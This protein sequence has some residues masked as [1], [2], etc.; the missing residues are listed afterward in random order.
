M[1]YWS[2]GFS[3]TAFPV[4]ILDVEGKKQYHRPLNKR[5]A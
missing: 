4:S 5:S 1:E 2:D 3:A